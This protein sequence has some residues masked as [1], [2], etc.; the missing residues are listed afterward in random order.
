MVNNKHSKDQEIPDTLWDFLFLYLR[1]WAMEYNKLILM[2]SN[3]FH[4]MGTD[5][6]SQL[7]DRSTLLIIMFNLS[8]SDK[9]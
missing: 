6:V 5:C 9:I 3:Y 4:L 7:L 8:T 1:E 2:D